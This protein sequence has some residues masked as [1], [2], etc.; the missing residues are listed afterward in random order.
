MKKS[1]F[2]WHIDLADRLRHPATGAGKGGAGNGSPGQ[3]KKPGFKLELAKA[4]AN[5]ARKR[6][7]RTRSGP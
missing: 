1:R 5:Q 7:F 4:P 2:N 6:Q 3:I